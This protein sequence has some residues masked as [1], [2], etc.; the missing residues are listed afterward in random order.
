MAFVVKEFAAILDARAPNFT[1]LPH[2]HVVLDSSRPLCLLAVAL[3]PDHFATDLSLE[4]NWN[5]PLAASVLQTFA[6]FAFVNAAVKTGELT[7]TLRLALSKVTNEC[8]AVLVR[9]HS[10]SVLEAV[11][12]VAFEDVTVMRSQNAVSPWLVV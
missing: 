12:E 2:D 4:N 10:S 7:V 5:R 11:L 8:A 9:L 1:S 6:K 3:Q